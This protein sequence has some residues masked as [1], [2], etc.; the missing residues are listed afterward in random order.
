MADEPFVLFLGF[1]G[2]WILLG[3][4][5]IIWVLKSENSDLKLNQDLILVSLSILI[6]FGLALMIGFTRF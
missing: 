6:P 2:L 3:V 1:S 4:G 5:T